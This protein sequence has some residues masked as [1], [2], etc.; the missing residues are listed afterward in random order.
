VGPACR[1][2][3]ANPK[4]L[5]VHPRDHWCAQT[6]HTRKKG[7]CDEGGGGLQLAT[8]AVVTSCRGS[9]HGYPLREE[10]WH[11]LHLSTGR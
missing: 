10:I 8:F 2:Q 6:A 5:Y 3:P 1:H 7:W 9:G 11:D 4:G